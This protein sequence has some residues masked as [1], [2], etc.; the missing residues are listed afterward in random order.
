LNII[1]MNAGDWNWWHPWT[2]F[3]FMDEWKNTKC[4]PPYGWNMKTT[5]KLC[6]LVMGILEFFTSF[7]LIACIIVMDYNFG[8]FWP[9]SQFHPWAHFHW[10]CSFDFVPSMCAHFSSI[11]V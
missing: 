6:L 10:G 2:Q 8:Q 9:W 7:P 11:M 1:H 5:M 4:T 3:F